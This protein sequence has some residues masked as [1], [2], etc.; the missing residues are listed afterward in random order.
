MKLTTYLK[1]AAIAVPFALISCRGQ[2]SEEEPVHPNMNMDQQD[3]FEGQE[4]NN[5]FSDNS[6]MR[7]PVEGTISR[8]NLREDDALYEGQNEDSS[9][10][11]EI[12]VDVTKSFLYRGQEQYNTYCSVCHGKT[13]GGNGVIMEGEY[14]YT[15]APDF[16]QSRIR[17]LADGEIYSAIANGIRTMPSYAHQIKVEDRWAIVAYIRALQRSQNASEEDVEQFGGDL[18]ALQQEHSEELAEE[19]EE[20]SGDSD[21]D[22]VSAER[23]EQVFQENACQSCHSVDGSGGMIG[24]TLA[25]LYG[26]EENLD[27]GST[28]TADEDY[29]IESIVEPNAKIVEGYDPVMAPYGHLSDAEVESLVEYIK[30]LSDNE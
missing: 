23:G 2:I 17:D 13:G 14:G 8:G 18:S 5:F 22:E 11:E 19:T 7:Q 9:F 3:R 20:D 28:V 16:H 21:E 26:N 24:P 15:P 4:E 29:L 1:I 10:I 25:D 30:T 6:S 12:P 27:D